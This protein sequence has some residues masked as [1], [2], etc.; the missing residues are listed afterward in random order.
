LWS[1]SSIRTCGKAWTCSS[2]VSLRY[3]IGRRLEEARHFP[4]GWRGTKAGSGRADAL[5]LSRRRRCQFHLQ[6]FIASLA[7]EPPAFVRRPSIQDRDSLGSVSLGEMFLNSPTLLSA[8][9]RKI[10]MATVCTSAK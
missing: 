8:K 1:L 4:R 3:V 6:L 5:P 9:E 7:A 2:I 10:S